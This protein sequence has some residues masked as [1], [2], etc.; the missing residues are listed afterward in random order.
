MNQKSPYKLLVLLIPLVVSFAF[1]LDIY[2]PIVP[3]MRR[4]MHA[5]TT[6]IQ[7]TLSIFM[8]GMG[9][10]QYFFGPL[11]DYYGRR[12]SALLSVM[13]FAVGSV[14]CASA[15]SIIPLMLGR[16][17]EALGGCGSMVVA[18]A[19]VRD[20]CDRQQIGS[21]Y[22]ALNSAIAIAPLT[23]PW[24]GAHLNQWFNWRAPFVF[25]TGF[26]LFVF[27]LMHRWLP[28]TLPIGKR[29]PI[30][31]K[32][33]IARYGYIAS[34]GAF[35]FYAFYVCGA[36]ACFFS[37]FSVSPYLLIQQLHVSQNAFGFYFGIIGFVYFIVSLLGSWLCPRLRIFKT[38]IL[39]ASLLCLGGAL[40]L[41]W[42]YCLGL[43]VLGFILPIAIAI[44]GAALILGA[45]AAGALAPFGHMAGSAAALLGGSQFLF[46][47][48]VGS[49]VVARSIES[50]VPLAFALLGL[51]G[52]M[53]LLAIVFC[54]FKRV[55]SICFPESYQR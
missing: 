47:S 49:C 39:G 5:S 23:A 31:L 22:N 25:L 34:Q 53:L 3:E 2:I 21:V 12:R 18:F 13:L 8:L 35:G 11:S 19:M 54:F 50:P 38:V 27:C 17:C 40:L 41:G 52:I 10:G 14:M 1:A 30:T 29:L 32:L 42:Y 45:G 48:I 28:E 24:L 37:F 33:L 16:F 43:S 20:T 36:I 4:I 7:W 26:S 6:Q 46:A 44:T 9:F 15:S 51:S 55:P